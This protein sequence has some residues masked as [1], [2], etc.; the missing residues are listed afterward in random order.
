MRKI[1]L[2]VIL[3]ALICSPVQFVQAEGKI[4]PDVKQYADEINYLAERNIIRGYTDGTF[5][6]ANS[7]TRLHAVQILLKAR[8]ITDFTAPDPNL[9]DMKP[10]SYGYAEVAKA[11]EL[12]IISGKIGADGTRYFDPSSYLT[13]GQMAKVIVEAAKLPKQQTTLFLDVLPTD[14]FHDY[15]ATLAAERITGGYE[16]GTYRPAN[17]ISRQH[18]AV[19]I[20]RMLDDRFKPAS[21]NK[22]PSFLMDTSKT[23]TWL[24]TDDGEKIETTLKKSALAYKGAVGWDLWQE[25]VGGSVGYFIVLENDNGL[26]EVECRYIDELV[27][28]PFG[29]TLSPELDYPL[30]KGKKWTSNEFVNYTVVSTSQ[31]VTT[32]AATFKNVVEVKDS[33]GWTYYYA[34]NVGLVKTIDN[35]LTFAELVKLQ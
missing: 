5:R 15:I 20:A 2:F 29:D 16:D 31:T 17:R 8:G 23:Y 22:A 13:R 11:V 21:V 28:E 34:P 26:F 4:F 7:L 35:G 19:F 32:K 10:T 3:F 30:Y 24:Y 14:G 18:F 25:A 33:D 1:A 12:G 9:T 6:P 27:C